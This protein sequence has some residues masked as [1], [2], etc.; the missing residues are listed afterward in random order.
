MVKRKTTSPTN[1]PSTPEQIRD[2]M[3][4]RYARSQLARARALPPV[5]VDRSNYKRRVFQR[6]RKAREIPLSQK[7]KRNFLSRFLRPK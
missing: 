4:L 2:A 7:T 6:R 5:K 3:R 1:F